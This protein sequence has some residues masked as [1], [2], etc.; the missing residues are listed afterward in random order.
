MPKT[1]R[2]SI[3]KGAPRR[4]GSRGDRPLSNDPP[5]NDEVFRSAK[6]LRK[7]PVRDSIDRVIAECDKVDAALIGLTQLQEM[8]PLTIKQV[9][10]GSGGAGAKR[11][12]AVVSADP[13]KPL[14]ER[15]AKGII[16]AMQSRGVPAPIQGSSQVVDGRDVA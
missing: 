2:K 13:G 9:E 14:T 12:W 15:Q 6:S 10:M 5:A 7:K 3:A 8:P 4:R 16:E 11:G 1:K